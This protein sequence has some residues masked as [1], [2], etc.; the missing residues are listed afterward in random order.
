MHK[1][2]L[3]LVDVLAMARFQTRVGVKARPGA[4]G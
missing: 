1:G 2:P 4:E 3:D